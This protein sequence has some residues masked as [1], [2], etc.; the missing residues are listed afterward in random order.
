[1]VRLARATA[2]SREYARETRVFVP[3]DEANDDRHFIFVKSLLQS[4]EIVVF[5]SGFKDSA[6]AAT[7]F[8]RNFPN[9]RKSVVFSRS[10]EGFS[11]NSEEK[12]KPLAPCS[13]P[14]TLS[15]GEEDCLRPGQR[16]DH[17]KSCYGLS[18]TSHQY[19]PSYLITCI[20]FMSPPQCRK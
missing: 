18:S 11:P 15:E 19:L 13:T 3:F 10:K 9:N 6:S 16:V 14:A 8:W 5:S 12:K 2:V 17:F 7:A 4:T 1:M 20:S